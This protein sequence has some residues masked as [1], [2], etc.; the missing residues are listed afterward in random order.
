MRQFLFRNSLF[1]FLVTVLLYGTSLVEASDS[2]WK[3]GRAKIEASGDVLTLRLS[4]RNE[5]KAGR[6]SLEILGRWKNTGADYKKLGS[7]TKEVALKQTAI[8]MVPLKALGT[9]PA[10]SALEITLKTGSKDTDHQVI[11]LP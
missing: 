3:A 4:L 10:G 5:G 9:A 2:A 6:E 11:P 8:L 7:Y 1:L